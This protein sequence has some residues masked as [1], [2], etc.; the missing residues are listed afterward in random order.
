MCRPRSARRRARPSW[1][2]EGDARRQ[3]ARGP[4][5][6]RLTAGAAGLLPLGHCWKRAPA[7]ARSA[8][9]LGCRSRG[10][11]AV[12]GTIPGPLPGLTYDHE[13]AHRGYDRRLFSARPL[14]PEERPDDTGDNSLA[15][16]FA[17]L[18]RGDL[19]LITD[20]CHRTVLFCQEPSQQ[21]QCCHL[22]PGCAI[23]AQ[24]SPSR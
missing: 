8:P 15:C 23:A 10:R 18:P 22:G 13:R 20:H 17:H 6:G 9:F 1:G 3:P 5:Q 2:V 16:G 21:G 4:L 24:N 12:A 7:A 11:L 19:H 14:H